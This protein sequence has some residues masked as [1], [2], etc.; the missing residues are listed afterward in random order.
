MKLIISCCCFFF[1]FSPVSGQEQ[2]DIVLD[3]TWAHLVSDLYRCVGTCSE[4]CERESLSLEFITKV[5]LHVFLCMK[6]ILF[7][8]HCILGEKVMVPLI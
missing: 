4:R 5:C 1:F 7:I 3:K 8:V 2:L 6:I